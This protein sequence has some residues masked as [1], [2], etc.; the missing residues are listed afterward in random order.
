MA[1]PLIRLLISSRSVN[2]HGH[3]RQFLFLIARFLKKKFSSE[4]AWPNEPK[5]CRKY[6]WQVLYSDCTFRLD[7]LTNMAA[8]G[9]YCF[10]F[11]DFYNFRIKTMFGSSLPPVV[12]RRTHVLFTLFVLVC[13]RL[14]YPMLTVS[15]GCLLI[16]PST[17]SNVYI[18]TTSVVAIVSP[19]YV[20]YLRNL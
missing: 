5:R 20:V 7:P 4:T 12:C 19:L 2:K 1:G 10:W 15:P 8:T 16:V 6:L 11:V 9:N 14:L 3:H 18:I 17:F 13:L